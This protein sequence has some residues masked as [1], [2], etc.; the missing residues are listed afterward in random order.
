VCL[1]ASPVVA[2]SQ[3]TGFLRG[4]EREI[5]SIYETNREGVVRI[6]ARLPADQT[7]AG[8]GSVY[9]HGSGFI[10]DPGGY[11]LTIEAAV[12]EAEDIRITLASNLE[13]RAHLVGS[14]PVSGLAVIRADLSQVRVRQ[15]PIVTLGDSEQIR[16]GHY[17]FILGNDFGNMVPAFGTVRDIFTDEDIIQVSTRLQSSYGGA[18]VFCSDGKVGGL[19]WRYQEE[20]TYS[21]SIDPVA[22]SIAGLQH[23]PGAVFV[24]P[25]NRAMRVARILMSKGEMI[26]GWLGV[27]VGMRGSDMVVLDVAPAKSGVL[28]GDVLQAFGDRPVAGPHHLRRLVMESSPGDKINLYIRR[29]G[30]VDVQAVQLGEMPRNTGGVTGSRNQ[31]LSDE[32]IGQQIKYM[33]QEVIRLRQLMSRERP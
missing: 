23:L 1:C 15:L 27:E 17:A 14:D 32:M 19:V 21:A 8:A 26:Y 3:E 29:A 4:I 30:V 5:T 9:A 31:P 6:H 12:L 10:F 22:G 25:I 7:S 28:P 18:P 2:R 24:I 11:I 33:Q 13:I 16:F 20:L